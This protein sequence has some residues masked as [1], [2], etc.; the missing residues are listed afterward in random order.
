MLDFA[1]LPIILILTT[2]VS[3][4]YDLNSLNIVTLVWLP[5]FCHAAKSTKKVK[6]I[7][8]SNG[9]ST[10]YGGAKPNSPLLRRDSNMVL[11]H[12]PPSAQNQDL[13][14]AAP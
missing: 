1:L 7:C 3:L 9:F 14:K 6:P 5:T 8:K 4:L 12:P 13:H 2:I 11:L 10:L